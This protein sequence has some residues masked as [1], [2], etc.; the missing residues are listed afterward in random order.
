MTT[1][2]RILVALGTHSSRA[3]TLDTAIELAH[4]LQYELYVVHVPSLRD[5]SVDPD[6]ED[7]KTLESDTL[8]S[9]A[10]WADAKLLNAELPTKLEILNG[11]PTTE[12]ADYVISKGIK[13]IV[14]G[15]NYS[16]FSKFDTETKLLHAIK[17]R[18]S[19]LPRLVIV[20]E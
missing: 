18:H 6:S 1:E 17:K 8:E 10:T 12:I 5:Y 3:K 16:A 7:W 2:D 13:T 11:D 19:T 9:F 15:L 20:P 14:L 4:A